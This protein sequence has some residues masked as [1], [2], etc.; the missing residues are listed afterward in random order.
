MSSYAFFSKDLGHWGESY[1]SP[2]GFHDIC[3][4]LEWFHITH[5]TQSELTS[6]TCL[7]A[8]GVAKKFCSNVTFLLVLAKEG[9]AVERVYGLIMVW[10][11]P[12]QARVSMID[13]AAKQLA[14]LASTGS[15]WPCALV[16]LNGDAQ[17]VSL[18]IEGHWSVMMEGNTSN[19]PHG[20]IHQLQVCQLLGSGSQVV[21]LEGLNGC[22]IPVI[23]TLPESLSNAVTM[24][25]GEST[26]LQV[27]L[28]QSSTKEQESKALSLGSDLSPTLAASPTRALPPKAEGQISMTMEVSKLLSWAVLDTSGLASGSS[29]PKD[30]S[31]WP[32]PHHYLLSRSISPNQWTPPLK[33]VFQMMWEWMTP[34]WRRSM[35]LLPLLSKLWGPVVKLPP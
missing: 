33:C 12:Y 10:V 13:G 17:H 25:E 24:L 34:P 3:P 21:Y 30:Q 18:P 1:Q 27:D 35:P 29:N 4:V 20:K 32:W 14:K 15:D 19:V 22:Q 8:W 6:L 31:P 26:F 23:K 28:S 9:S 2:W 7:K 16:W 5:V 11:H